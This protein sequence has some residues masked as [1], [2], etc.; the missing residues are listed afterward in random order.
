MESNTSD[1]LASSPPSSP[2]I[3]TSL[4][5]MRRFRSKSAHPSMGELSTTW[6]PFNP[7]SNIPSG[8]EALVMV[9]RHLEAFLPA[10]SSSSSWEE[11][12][13]KEPLPGSA[14]AEAATLFRLIESDKMITRF[15]SRRPYRLFHSKILSRLTDSSEWEHIASRDDDIIARSSLVKY[16]GT[17][18]ISDKV[19]SPFGQFTNPSTGQ[20]YLQQ[21]QFPAIIRVLYTPAP[22]ATASFQHLATVTMTSPYPDS[23]PGRQAPIQ[24]ETF[25]DSYCLIASARLANQPGE[26]DYVRLYNLEGTFIRHPIAHDDNADWKLGERGHS[27]M[28]FY[29]PIPWGLEKLGHQAEV[30]ITSDSEKRTTSARLKYGS[31]VSI[32]HTELE[33]VAGSQRQE[34]HPP[35]ATGPRP[36]RPSTPYPYDI[37]SRSP[38]ESSQD[39]SI[40]GTYPQRFEYVSGSSNSP[41]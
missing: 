16:D 33:R 7:A 32:D 21:S 6:T 29:T 19:S 40:Q 9:V 26:P 11:D 2:S 28:L 8:F 3:Q 27:Y 20:R 35:P 17:G 15:W 25:R 39:S 18:S 34:S 41:S 24:P 22:D 5:P 30:V 23:A 12:S 10:S 13:E 38:T 37:P 1:T 36:Y 31:Q 4:P 14:A